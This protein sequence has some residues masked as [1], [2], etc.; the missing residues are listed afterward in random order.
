[1]T[2][3]SSRR[4][5]LNRAPAR[6]GWASQTRLGEHVFTLTG[7]NDKRAG[8]KWLG[9]RLGYPNQ[10]GREDQDRSLEGQ[11]ILESIKADAK[12][13]ELIRVRLK[14]GMT[15]VTTDRPSNAQ[16]RTSKDFVVISGLY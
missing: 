1:M 8:L 9:A 2:I 11:K 15:L 13:R 14:N 16:T 4:A 6:H 12:T 10:G 5:T 7:T 3:G